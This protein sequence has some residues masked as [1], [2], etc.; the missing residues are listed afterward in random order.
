MRALKSK[1]PVF[2][3]VASVVAGSTLRAQADSARIGDSTSEFNTVGVVSVLELLR[4]VPGVQVIESNQPG[5]VITVRIRGASSVNGS[6]DPLF[7]VD[8]MP[9]GPG[10]GLTV[11]NDPLEFLDPADVAGITVVKDGTGALYGR[12]SNG[13]VV[14]TTRSGHGA[15][16]VEYG[17][18]FS[19]SWVTRVPS[20][21]DAAQFRS[22]V[23]RYDSAGLSQLGTAST[24]WFDLV[25]RT[26]TGLTQRVSFS[27]GDALGDYRMAAGYSDLGGVVGGSSTRRASAALDYHVRLAHRLDLRAGIRG[28]RLTDGFTPDGVLQDAAAMGPTQ[29]VHDAAAA[30]GYYNWPGNSLTSADNP[31]EILATSTDGATTDRGLANLTARYDFSGI[32]P[33]EGLSAGITLGYDVLQATRTAIYPNDIHY[34]TKNGTDG[35]FFRTQPHADNTLVDASL[36]YTPPLAPGAGHLDLAV[37]Y[38]R[39]RS[40]ARIPATYVTQLASNPQGSDGVPPAGILTSSFEADYNTLASVY[41]RVGYDLAGR[42]FLSAGVRRDGSSRFSSENEWAAFPTI[43]AGWRVL[44]DP[45]DILLR[46]SWGETG[47]QDLGSGIVSGLPYGCQLGGAAP[48]AAADP[49]LTWET[50]HAWDVGADF[51]LAGRR[52]TGSVDWYDKRTD[53]L[54]FVIPVAAG[55]SFSNYVLTNV[56]SMRNSG[57]E[58]G[59]TGALVRP[60]A[61][62]AL[63][64]TVTLNASHNAN[65][66]L[67]FNPKF[68]LDA[69]QSQTILT[70]NIAGG[71]GST[72]QVI[73]PGEPV[74]SFYVCRQVYSGGKPLEGQYLTLSGADTTGCA[75]G[76]NTVA[77]HDPAPHWIFGVTSNLTWRRFDV[78]VTLRAWVGNYVYDNTA[79]N[80]GD[81]RELSDGSSPYNLSTSVLATGFQTQQLL[82]DYYVEN[83]SFLRLDD[84]MVGYTF[85]WRGQALRV[86]VD[87]RNALTITG[88]GGVDPTTAPNGIDNGLYPP[89]RMVT[90]GLTVRI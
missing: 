37:G 31:V 85:P 88:Y 11:G 90:G 9:L 40:S 43:S 66:F 45:T 59:L 24:D 19:A 70:G 78:S 8:G 6:N 10:G 20:V 62:D 71:V 39:W 54:L 74:N 22:A 89:S 35:E 48:C 23:T 7:V 86:Y 32:R 61:P 64:W 63:S 65:T 18:S 38:S 69:G 42:Y 17:G 47:N 49:S 84:V 34:E 67:G 60:R 68:M 36:G 57:V 28:A 26:G 27:G 25:D 72:I 2:V 1:V 5:G 87:V 33:L 55:P 51:G 16:H 77:E 4:N 29:P 12:A 14:I 80:L 76:E 15:P 50:T 81:Y 75:R 53:N 52:L 73:E 44:R 83:G 3:L 21:L 13:V 56:G 46:A 41:G 79:S 82:S 30:T 58:L